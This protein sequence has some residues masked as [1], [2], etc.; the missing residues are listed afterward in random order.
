MNIVKAS[1]ADLMDVLYLLRVCVHE[2]NGKGWFHWDLQ[3][4][5]LKSDIEKGT[6]FL[7]KQNEACVGALT[8]NNEEIAEYKEILWPSTSHNP[9]FIHRLMVHPFWRE[10]GVAG[11]LMYFAEGY[12]REQG[13]SSLR[14]E[15]NSENDEVINLFNELNYNKIGEIQIQYQKSPYYCFEKCF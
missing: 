12:A 9:L 13:Y 10:K 4:Q 6:T 11:S 3:N 7:Y 1:S 5:L 15:V 14:L 8:I 2:M